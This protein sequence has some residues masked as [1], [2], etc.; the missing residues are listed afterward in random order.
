MFALARDTAVCSAVVSCRFGRP[1]VSHAALCIRGGSRS[2]LVGRRRDVFVQLS[3]YAT[4]SCYVVGCEPVSQTTI[5]ARGGAAHCAECA[6]AGIRQ[7][8]GMDAAV[9]WR[10]PPPE[11]TVGFHDVEVVRER[12]ATDPDCLGELLLIRG[13]ARLDR[14]Q[15]EPGRSRASCLGERR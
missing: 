13:R 15:D 3:E 11:Q 9:C 7:L 2:L 8:D 1:R 4:K 6:M 10:A 12:G 14:G 5:E